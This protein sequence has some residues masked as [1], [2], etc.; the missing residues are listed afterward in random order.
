MV[1]KEKNQAQNGRDL[2]AVSGP[3]FE[4]P[5]LK[6]ETQMPGVQPGI[7]K[8][9][10]SSKK[11]KKP[12]RAQRIV[13]PAG[14]VGEPGIKPYSV[15]DKESVD[16]FVKVIPFGLIALFTKNQKWVLT[17][18]EVETLSIAADRVLTKYLPDL[19][20]EYLDEVQLGA[21]IIT[22][23]IKKLTAP[24]INEV[25]VKEVPGND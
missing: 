13:E 23:F 24:D 7:E 4:K 14:E 9:P 25:P 12:K 8:I 19:F 2:Q 17:E 6:E 5:E 21:V 3:A 16:L 20:T 11:K 10:V 1:E 15:L 22:I 18:L